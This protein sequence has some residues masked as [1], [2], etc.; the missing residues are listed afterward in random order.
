MYAFS[1]WGYMQSDIHRGRGLSRT[2]LQQS[3]HRTFR[4]TKEPL[5]ESE[6]GE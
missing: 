6:R 3:I 2:A 1:G 4:R 5:D